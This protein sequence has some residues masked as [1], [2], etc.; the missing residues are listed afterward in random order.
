[1]PESGAHIPLLLLSVSFDL[2]NE[3]FK[4]SFNYSN[5]F[6]VTN[7]DKVKN[8]SIRAQNVDIMVLHI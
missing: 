4:N 8:E 6:N 1:M 7:N 2:V 5:R 3:I